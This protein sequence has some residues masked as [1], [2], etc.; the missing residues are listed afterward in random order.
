LHPFFGYHEQVRRI[1]KNG[2]NKIIVRRKRALMM[3][4]GIISQSRNLEHFHL[5]FIATNA[6]QWLFNI[7]IV[8]EFSWWL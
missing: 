4:W 2:G 5:Q 8:E 3:N 6:N 7:P 1:G